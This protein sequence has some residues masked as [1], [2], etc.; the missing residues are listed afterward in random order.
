[1]ADY[2]PLLARALDALPDRSPAMRKAVYDRARSA[3]IGQLRSLEPPLS[4]D[5]ID[6]ESKALD[7]AIER[8]EIDYGGVP[9]PAN[10]PAAA[11]AKPAEPA[12][13]PEPARAPEPARIPE[14][15]RPSD[16]PEAAPPPAPED[17]LFEPEPPKPEI[18]KPGTA[19]PRSDAL[20]TG[21]P[22][23]SRPEP[24]LPPAPPPDLGPSPSAISLPEPQREP[25]IA[26]T[27]RKA[28][29]PTFVANDAAAG[30]AAASEALPPDA[31]GEDAG[32]AGEAANGRQR[33]RIDVVAP[34]G[35]RSRMLRNIFVGS[36]LAV[37]IGLIAVA[38]FLLRD[39][40]A[41]LQ[42]SGAETAGAPAEGSDAK[43]S[44][45]VGG[46]QAPGTSA[47]PGQG[48][49]T[50]P[51]PP[52]VPQLSPAEL[53]VAQRAVLIEENTSAQNNQATTTPGRV[54][55]R[56]DSV[57][58]EQGQPLETAIVANVEFPD[59][60]L[61]LTMTI[62]RN[63]DA[64]LPASHTIKLAFTDTGPEGEKRAV[65]D[66][67][68]LQAKDDENGR[69]S[70][71]SGLPVRVRENLFLIGLSS[72]R[73]DIDRNTDL[74]LHKNWFDL[75]VRYASGQRAVLTFEKGNSGTQQMQRAFDQW[76]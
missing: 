36:V 67:G 19:E 42:T 64:T 22:A 38:A 1:M 47:A 65:Q 18:A 27:P 73:N 56:L 7:S 21:A 30:E 32:R 26:I 25:A 15:A 59:A 45:R 8:L 39:K 6:L 53:A 71:V 41:D 12:R 52:P 70:P 10:D 55:W 23:A 49:A 44:D 37:V 13:V 35:G 61:A 16:L 69:G 54:V 74:L 24:G 5:D 62:Q 17:G 51:A 68:L 3:L 50:A 11:R 40:P 4:Q 31:G 9:A 29:A 75:A 63:L 43:F 2:Y 14:P 58:G 28:K 46:E 60:G 34:R 20:K 76:K 72:L 57:S 66:V 48:G 33:P